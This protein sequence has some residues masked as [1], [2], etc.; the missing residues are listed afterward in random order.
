MPTRY[1]FGYPSVRVSVHPSVR[2]SSRPSIRSFI[3]PSACLFVHPAVH[4]LFCPPVCSSAHMFVSLSVRRLFQ[5]F[6]FL[7]AWLS[8]RLSV[9]P[10]VCLPVCSSVLPPAGLSI[11]SSIR[12]YAFIPLVCL[13]VCSSVYPSARLSIRLSVRPSAVFFQYFGNRTGALRITSKHQHWGF[14]IYCITSNVFKTIIYK[15]IPFTNIKINI[16]ADSV[17]IKECMQENYSKS[18]I[19][20]WMDFDQ[21]FNYVITMKLDYVITMKR[22]CARYNFH[23]VLSRGCRVM[24]P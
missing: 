14:F 8:A 10:S 22:R 15:K 24:C 3:R 7:P 11:R 21:L 5:P 16:N 9:R 6:V 23:L 12:P 18:A 17:I 2:L 13:P 19:S 20:W 4:P 1:L